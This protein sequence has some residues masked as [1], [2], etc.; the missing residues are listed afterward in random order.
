M[1]VPCVLIGQNWTLWKETM[2]FGQNWASSDVPFSIR[3]LL[4]PKNG[5]KTDGLE[6][7]DTM[8]AELD[9]V[10]VYFRE[11]AAAFPATTAAAR[12]WLRPQTESALDH[13]TTKSRKRKWI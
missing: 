3:S 7:N 2:G 6:R 10:L 8:H 12:L 13:R 11:S 5:Q 1:S 4:A 9:S